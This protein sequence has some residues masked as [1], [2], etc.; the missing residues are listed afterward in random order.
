M[1]SLDIGKIVVLMGGKSQEREISLRSGRAVHQ[2]L[3]RGGYAAEAIALRGDDFTEELEAYSF[4]FAFVT[5]HGQGG[6]DGEIQTVL[7]KRGVPYLGSDPA[8]SFRAFD[9]DIAKGIFLNHGIPTPRYQILP[10]SIKSRLVEVTRPCLNLR[11]PIFL[12]PP[13]Q[14]SSIDVYL[15]EQREVLR[16]A[17]EALFSRYSVLVAEEKVEGREITVGILGDRVLPVV[18]IRTRRSFYDYEA[19]YR[20]GFTEYF[21]PADLPRTV[22]LAVQECA[23][24]TH[25]AL[26]LRDFSR[27][28]MILTEEGP[29]VLEANT[30]PGFTESSLLPKAA[31]AYG[32]PFDALC[33]E[34]VRIALARIKDEKK[35]NEEALVS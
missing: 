17:L 11:Y 14:G 22:T 12:K 9:K 10:R 2:A 35:K 27:V 20:P 19:K 31:A 3:L 26:G 21:V 1:S 18:E 13:R 7:E 33:E 16:P 24:R 8:A 23:L 34:L 32:F 28:D 15:V 30:I 5:L 6:E 29:F 25:R 4:D